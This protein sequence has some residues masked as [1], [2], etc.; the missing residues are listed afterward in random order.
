MRLP[1]IAMNVQATAAPSLTQPG[2]AEAIG[3]VGS[4]DRIIIPGITAWSDGATHTCD[5]LYLRTGTATSASFTMRFGFRAL[6]TANGPP[7]RDTGG[8]IGAS[9][10]VVNPASNTNY[11]LTLAT[12]LAMA[13]G[14]PFCLVGDFS[15]YASGSIRVPA[16]LTAVTNQHRSFM[17]FFNGTTYALV[18]TAMVPT[19]TIEA[20][21][22]TWGTFI[23][24]L[25]QITAAITTVTFANDDNP[26]ERALAFELQ[27]AAFRIDANWLITTVAG[28]T[29][30][31]VLYN[32]TTE[33]GAV[34]MDANTW[35]ADATTRWQP[36]TFGGDF[37]PGTYRVALR[38][39]TTTDVT[40]YTA[41]LAAN[42]IRA[43]GGLTTERA[44]VLGFSTRVDG[45]AWSAPDNTVLPM[46]CFVDIAF[47]EAA[48]GGL[49]GSL[50]G[51][52]PLFG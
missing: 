7:G 36:A 41:T 21:D 10:T 51:P 45:G 20:D 43:I 29:Y 13:H 44:Y 23:P 50:V 48:A 18:T 25:P 46:N 14:A 28:G 2:A 26:D 12:P 22:G 19:F 31:L 27:Q 17:T 1:R 15:A 8:D 33:L 37:Q 35:D 11:T 39:T 24:A 9:G 32:G 40:F 6:D 47:A 16:G 5:T 52:G 30:E 38:P 49:A 4:T 42:H 34:T 3:S